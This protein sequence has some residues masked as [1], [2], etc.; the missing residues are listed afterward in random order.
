VTQDWA[1]SDSSKDEAQGSGVDG[2]H[3][4]GI[5][6][7]RLQADRL[8]GGPSTQPHGL[9]P[10]T[11]SLPDVVQT[12][13]GTPTMGVPAVSVGRAVERRSSK[14]S[15]RSGGR[16]RSRPTT[17]HSRK[18]AED[19]ERPRANRLLLAYLVIVLVVLAAATT[20]GVWL[21]LRTQRVNQAGTSGAETAARRTLLVGLTD[22]SSLVAAAL[23]GTGA[24]AP[25]C[26]AVPSSLLVDD[27]QG[28]VPL[29]RA[30]SGGVAVAG[31]ALARTLDVPVDA[32]WLLTTS[33]LTTLVDG[34]GGVLVDVDQELRSGTVL[35]AAGKGQRLTGAQA[36]VY[37]TLPRDGEG[38]PAVAQRFAD[39]LG[40][41]V[42]AL[43]PQVADA[44]AQLRALGA[45][46]TST[47]P[48]DRLAA[49][50]ATLGR[51]VGDA[52]T[53]AVTELPVRSADGGDAAAGVVADR[54]VAR[55]L[56]R[57]KLGVTG[58]TGAA[59][60]STGG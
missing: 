52:G 23:V 53:L 20:G 54:A 56:V 29:A 5:R 7:E 30:A 36:A 21:T 28:R 31:Q 60:S 6:T 27:A 33:A 58:A 45:G 10:S 39:L 57:G 47:L 15:R 4:G 38:A 42:G 1:A 32:S 24:G 12:A 13:L 44:A 2:P 22:G 25:S 48:V 55:D 26:V 46:S 8:V 35:V 16:A 17:R 18:G 49:L 51:R 34:G 37:V 59:T 14:A 41:V 43:P 50:V 9:G 11:G 40:Q 3:T 19:A